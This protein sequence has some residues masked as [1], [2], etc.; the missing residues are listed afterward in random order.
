LRRERIAGVGM[1]Q[2]EY[3]LLRAEHSRA[4]SFGFLPSEMTE[5]VE[6]SKVSPIVA[7]SGPE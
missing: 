5:P 1:E 3:E 4:D 2:R 7:H 6:L